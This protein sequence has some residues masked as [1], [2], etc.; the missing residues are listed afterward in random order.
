MTISFYSRFNRVFVFF[1]H[2]NVKTRFWLNNLLFCSKVHY[3]IFK[4]AFLTRDFTCFF[5]CFYMS[6][7]TLFDA[8]FCTLFDACFWAFLRIFPFFFHSRSEWTLFSLTFE[9][10]TFQKIHMIRFEIPLHCTF[11]LNEK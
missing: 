4:H 1:F 5:T 6:F 8:C 11:W 10:L 7:C 2:V 9:F 3:T